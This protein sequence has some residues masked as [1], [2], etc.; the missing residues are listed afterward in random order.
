MQQNGS[1]QD[2]F[3][4][5]IIKGHTQS[6][7]RTKSYIFSGSPY[8]SS[9]DDPIQR[10]PTRDEELIRPGLKAR[11]QTTAYGGPIQSIASTPTTPSTPIVGTEV[12]WR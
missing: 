4:R 9:K 8:S 7:S 3:N 2:P 10:P 1:P 12:S 11:S 6:L 5:N